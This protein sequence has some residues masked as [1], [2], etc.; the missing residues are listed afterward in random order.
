MWGAKKMPEE[1]ELTPEEQDRADA[2]LDALP[3]EYT[4]GY[5]YRIAD[6]PRDDMQSAE[7]LRGWDAADRVLA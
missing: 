3:A 7:W 4:E 5:G 1:I 2:A 6:M